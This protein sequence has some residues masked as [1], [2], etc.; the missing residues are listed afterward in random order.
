MEQDPPKFSSKVKLREKATLEFEACETP[1][2]AL[3]GAGKSEV[4]AAKFMRA[5]R[6]TPAAARAP[7]RRE[8]S[9]PWPGGV[10]A[11]FAAHVHYMEH[12]HGT[13]LRTGHIH[14]RPSLR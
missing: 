3:G 8:A 2:P 12:I 6:A 11:C 13:Y 14:E 9:R 10:N 4:A 1:L 7:P 5:P